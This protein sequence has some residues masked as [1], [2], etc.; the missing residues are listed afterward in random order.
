MEIEKKIAFVFNTINT[1]EFVDSIKKDKPL[2]ICTNDDIK[3]IYS[4]LGFDVKTIKEYSSDPELE[5]KKAVEWMKDWPDKPILNGKS[6]KELLIYDDLSIFWF[7]ETRFYIYRIQSLI[8]LIM[9][10]QNVINFEKPTSIWIKG[11]NDIHHIIKELCE[12]KL[13]KLEFI[14]SNKKKDSTS[15]KSHSG[16]RSV[17]LLA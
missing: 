14:Q 11:S 15:Y 6:F 1:K 10:I 5:N 12:N 3:R 4:D 2:I 13:K 8:P 7:L 17:K 16:N 9:Q